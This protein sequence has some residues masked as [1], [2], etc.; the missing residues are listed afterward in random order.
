MSFQGIGDPGSMVS[1]AGGLF[2]DGIVFPQGRYSTQP[3][4]SPDPNFPAGI[5][6]NVVWQ[7]GDFRTP[8]TPSIAVNDRRLREDRGAFNH[9]F[10]AATLP[11]GALL[12]A[13]VGAFD[14]TQPDSGQLTTEDPT[15]M[16]AQGIP[17]NW[18][19]GRGNW[20]ESDFA[21]IRASIVGVFGPPNCQDPVTGAIQSA[22]WGGGMLFEFVDPNGDGLGDIRINFK[23][24]GQTDVSF[25]II[26]LW[27]IHS[28]MR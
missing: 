1:I 11:P 14:L 19:R 21:N 28:M 27:F 6:P 24:L 18:G 13:C 8:V 23:S 10:I 5:G 12:G 7:K 22:I 2:Q 3:N 4:G 15:G 25:G 9:L 16:L 26:E 20:A 17:A